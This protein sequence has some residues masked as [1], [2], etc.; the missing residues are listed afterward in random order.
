MTRGFSESNGL[1]VGVRG[2]EIT[3]EALGAYTQGQA[4]QHL[5]PGSKPTWPQLLDALAFALTCECDS[6]DV[7]S[8]PGSFE[9]RQVR[10]TFAA[11]E[12]DLVGRQPGGVAYEETLDQVLSV[13]FVR[14]A[15]HYQ[16]GLKRRPSIAEVL[17]CLAVCL[18]ERAGEYLTGPERKLLRLVV[19]PRG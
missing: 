3:A 9:A 7:F 18:R 12:A 16:D 8:D 14:I 1:T 15:K 19:E 10:A 13:I 5:A 11:P 17:E 4:W 6:G 2:P